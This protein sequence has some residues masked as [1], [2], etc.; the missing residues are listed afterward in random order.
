[1][2]RQDAEPI[3]GEVLLARMFQ[4]CERVVS[5]YKVH[6]VQSVYTYRGVDL[7]LWC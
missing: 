7:A 3:A 1:M 6:I 5:H 2:G 4:R